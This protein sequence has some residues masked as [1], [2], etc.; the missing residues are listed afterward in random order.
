MLPIVSCSINWVKLLTLQ[1]DLQYYNTCSLNDKLNV[2]VEVKLQLSLSYRTAVSSWSGS[3]SHII[4]RCQRR[5]RHENTLLCSGGTKLFWA[6][7]YNGID[8]IFVMHWVGG[9]YREKLCLQSQLWP[10]TSLKNQGTVS[11][12]DWPRPVNHSFIPDCY[13]L[14]V[15]AALVTSMG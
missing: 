5:N 9:L 1:L 11:Q 15:T 14:N 3:R 10:C 7:R 12:I 2:L 8:D 6:E 4:K 13:F